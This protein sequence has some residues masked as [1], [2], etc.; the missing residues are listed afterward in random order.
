MKNSVGKKEVREA[1]DAGE[2]ALASL[3][4]AE[5]KLDSAKNW[6]IWD[7]LGG[8]LFTSMVKHSRLDD[9]AGCME[10]AKRELQIFSR[11]LQDVD[12][13]TDFKIE[14]SSFLSFADFFF[15][16]LVADYMV[17]SRIA[18][19][20]GQV[21]DAVFHVSQLLDGLKQVYEREEK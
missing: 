10:N 3:E 2:R 11:E 21:K 7:M 15:D 16:G 5:E 14:I 8:G 9:A 6:G 4:M 19:A 20:R 12:V 1:I 13:P 18:D 17:Q